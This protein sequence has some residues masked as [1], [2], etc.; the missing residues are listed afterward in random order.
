VGD[1]RNH[2][3]DFAV[4]RKRRVPLPAAGPFPK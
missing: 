4:F 2:I 3:L 1:L